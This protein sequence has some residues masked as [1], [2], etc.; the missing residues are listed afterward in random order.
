M[1]ED[2]SSLLFPRGVAVV[3]ASPRPGS[4][5]GEILRNIL[6]CGYGGAVYPVNP[7]Y[8]TVEELPCFSSLERVPAPVDLAVVAVNKG[9]VLDVVRS[10]GESGIKNVVVITAGFR[11]I[12]GEGEAREEALV[13][14][15]RSFGL[16]LVGPNCMGIIHSTPQA[17]LNASFSRFFPKSGEIAFVS[18]SGSLGETV[19]EFFEEMDLGV[20]LFVNLGNRADLSE[21]DFLAHLASDE[22]SRVIFLY[23]E[24]FADPPGFRRLV[25]EIGAKKPVV[26]LKAGRTE[27]GAAAVASHTGSLASSDAIV[28]AFLR[29][30]GAIRVSSI[31]ELLT[32]LPALERGVIPR[33]RRTVILTN[34][35]GAGIIAADACERAGLKVPPLRF[36]VREKLACFLPEEAGLGNPIDLIATAT[37]TD[38]E[39]ALRTTIPAF[40]AAIVIFRPPLVLAEAG[41]AVADGILR[42]AEEV[43]DKPLLVCTLSRGGAVAPF[44]ERLAQARIPTYTMPEE[45]VDALTILCQLGEERGEKVRLVRSEP[46]PGQGVAQRVVER[47][48]KEGRSI[49]SFQE[50]AEILSAYGIGVS[51]FTYAASFGEARSFLKG[52]GFPIVAKVDAPGLLHRTERGAVITGITDAKGLRRALG[53]LRDVIAEERFL[54]ARI[55]L[56]PLLSGRELFLGMK[57]DPSFGPVLVFGLGGTW[58]EALKDV[59]FGVPPLSSSQAGRMIR[60]IRAFPLLQR[61]RGQP[62]VSLVALA[63]A[64]KNLGR[65]GLDLEVVR[66]VDLNPFIAGER[67]AAVDILIKLGGK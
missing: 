15:V 51:P 23:L 24:S 2:L 54:E 44:I 50:G 27:A 56:Q 64:L 19:L 53:M 25:E 6:R 59:V 4:V 37:S 16:N 46:H 63:S 33:G 22:T 29:D 36:D 3:G 11:E 65:L 66:E 5:G 55:L 42:V 21:N 30:S 60:S 17:R 62:P 38:Y 18:Q 1:R 52:V 9:L 57:R 10:C 20:S 45:A 28:D 13:E 32:A 35:G 61:F 26:V 40:D 41:E 12:G 47:A 67:A 8:E 7:K 43:D 14:L 58:V 48:R 39:R 34:A 31:A 49:L